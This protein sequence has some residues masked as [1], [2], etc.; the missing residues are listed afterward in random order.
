MNLRRGAVVLGSSADWW[1]RRGRARSHRA[2]KLALNPG[3]CQ[4]D[5]LPVLIAATRLI[6]P[7]GFP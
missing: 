1:S 3:T 6:I 7:K 5:K 2:V 4:A